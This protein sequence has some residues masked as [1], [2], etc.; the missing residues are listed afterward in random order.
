MKANRK[1]SIN[2][3]VK[4]RSKDNSDEEPSVFMKETFAT[5]LFAELATARDGRDTAEERK[6]SRQSRPRWDVSN[7]ENRSNPRRTLDCV[8]LHS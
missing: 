7:L 2:W 6:E 8:R 1:D 4:M 5:I 3:W